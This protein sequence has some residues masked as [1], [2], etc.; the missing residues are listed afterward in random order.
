V[1][2]QGDDK[3]QVNPLALALAKLFL[4]EIMVSLIF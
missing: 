4:V 1:G 2:K 3:V